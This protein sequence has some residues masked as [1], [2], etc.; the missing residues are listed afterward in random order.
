MS[1]ASILHTHSAGPQFGTS[2]RTSDQRKTVS[3]SPQD[4]NRN[5]L[6]GLRP[7]VN[8]FDAYFQDEFVWL[9]C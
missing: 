4:L 2:A 7:V 8:E 5:Y 9:S 3:S 6:P 1:Q